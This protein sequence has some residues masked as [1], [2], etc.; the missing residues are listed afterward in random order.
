MFALRIDIIINMK[1]LKLYSNRLTRISL[2]MNK[3]KNWL[4]D[5]ILKFFIILAGFKLENYFKDI[6]INILEYFIF[7][8]NIIH[9]DD[10]IVL[11]YLIITHCMEFDYEYST[12]QVA[13]I[14]ENYSNYEFELRIIE[15]SDKV[16]PVLFKNS[17]IFLNKN[18]A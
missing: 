16:F 13:V 11:C 8:N 4:R 17:D 3:E 5:S 7:K 9:Y 10:I 2:Q 12:T 1:F 15:L 18:F 14:L 6:H